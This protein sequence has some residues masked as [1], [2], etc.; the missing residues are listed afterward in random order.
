M[1]R[2]SMTTYGR[3]LDTEVHRHLADARAYAQAAY[4]VVEGPN[5]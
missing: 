2:V 3:P 1:W 4:D 5:L